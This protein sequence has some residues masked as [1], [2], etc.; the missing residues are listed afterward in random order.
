[1]TVKNLSLV[2]FRKCW[3]VSGKQHSRGRRTRFWII[4]CFSG[5]QKIFWV[6]DS[7]KNAC[8]FQEKEG[9]ILNHPII[10]EILMKSHFL[11]LGNSFCQN[12]T[13]Y[14]YSLEKYGFQRRS[15]WLAIVSLNPHHWPCRIMLV[16][17]Q[18]FENVQ[19]FT[20]PRICLLKGEKIFAF[21]FK[22][23]F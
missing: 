8:I 10:R 5:I 14:C 4:I 7:G 18:L 16:K 22:F 12:N 15:K 1:M 6:A 19:W 23:R 2:A 21:M 13:F 11:T 3:E 20:S 9:G 17:W